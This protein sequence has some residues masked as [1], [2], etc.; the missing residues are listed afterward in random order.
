MLQ[1]WKSLR[2]KARFMV[3]AGLGVLI[4]AVSAL[5]LLSWF[6][7]SLLKQRFRSAAENE[8]TSLAALVESAM[9]QRVSDSENVAI[10]VFNG[11][12]ESRNSLTAS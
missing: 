9:E 4:F 11:W 8:L 5:A 1:W 7:L 3:Y 10:K 2:L 6:E 12:F